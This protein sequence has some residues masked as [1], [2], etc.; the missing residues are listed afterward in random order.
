MVYRY[1]PPI[2][3]PGLVRAVAGNGIILTPTKR[4]LVVEYLRWI[5]L[6]CCAIS[7]N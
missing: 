7:E 6:T 3:L 4:I 1:T 5:M 2:V